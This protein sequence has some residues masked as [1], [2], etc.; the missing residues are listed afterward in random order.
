MNCRS[1]RIWSA[2][3]LALT[4]VS[5]SVLPDRPA[6]PAVHDFGLPAADKRSATGAWTAAT[7]TAPDWLRDP[8]LR[9]RLLYRQPTRIQFYALD[10]WIAPPPDLLAQRLSAAAG[11]AGCPLRVDLQTFEQVFSQPGQ[12]RVIVELQ[13]RAAAPGAIA[14]QPLAEQR[15]ALSRPCPTPDAAGAV[16]AFSLAMD[17]AVS[18][19]DTWL[20]TLPAGVAGACR[21]A[22]QDSG[23]SVH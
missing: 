21:G 22:Q 18:R 16:A 15:F 9:Y 13:A 14:D 6:P 4:S 8:R 12:A 2:L 5:C 7:V 17:D 3:M 10:R 23:T 20:R 19:L 11:P 1:T